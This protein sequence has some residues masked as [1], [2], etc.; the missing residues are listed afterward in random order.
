VD[1]KRP[2]F[3]GDKAED[4]ACGRRAGL[5]TIQA[6]TSYGAGEPAQPDFTAPDFAHTAAFVLSADPLRSGPLPKPRNLV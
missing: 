3:I 2:S 6:L 5:R 4:I 1:L